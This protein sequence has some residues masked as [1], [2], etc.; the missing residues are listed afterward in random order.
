MSWEDPVPPVLPFWRGMAAF[1][2]AILL[3]GGLLYLLLA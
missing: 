1:A 2:A 3:S